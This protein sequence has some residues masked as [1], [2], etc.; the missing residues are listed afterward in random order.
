MMCLL[1]ALAIGAP[2]A[3]AET[4][5]M[6]VILA[7]SRVHRDEVRRLRIRRE[8]FRRLPPPQDGMLFRATPLGSGPRRFRVEVEARLHGQRAGRA[9]LAFRWGGPPTVVIAARAIPKGAVIR[10][11]DVSLAPYDGASA[12]LFVSSIS[13]VVG[14]V[15]RHAIAPG[16]SLRRAS[17]RKQYLVRRGDTVEVIVTRGGLSV[18][19]KAKALGSGGAGEP[20]RVRNSRSRR[21]I[22][23]T[24]TSAGRAEVRQ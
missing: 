3:E 17:V 24:V 21:I 4:P 15:A 5:G 10:A 1:A 22:D 9:V 16:V 7:A 13:D 14:E 2:V 8:S 6:A 12:D 23:A 20:V 11:E 19:L 18:T